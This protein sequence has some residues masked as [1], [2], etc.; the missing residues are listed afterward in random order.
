MHTI[1]FLGP[2]G[3]NGHDAALK[4]VS[5]QQ[6]KKDDYILIPCAS[7]EAIIQRFSQTE[8]YAILP[9][10]NSTTDKEVTEVVQ[11]MAEAAKDFT[12]SEVDTFTLTIHHCLLAHKSV[13]DISEL[14]SVMSHWQALGQCTNT[15]DK[16]GIIRRIDVKST[17]KAALHV[18]RMKKVPQ[19]GAIATRKAAIIYGLNILLENIENTK[20]NRT[21]F[22]VYHHSP[23]VKSV[24]VGIIGIKGKVGRALETFF[25]SLGCRVIGSDK[26]TE[27]TNEQVVLQADVVVFAV[28]IKYTEETI[29]S[30]VS[31]LGENQ[32]VMDMT[33]IKVPAVGAMKKGK[34]EILSLHQMFAPSVKNWKGQT[35]IGCRIKINKWN[36]W[37]NEML[38]QTRARIH[39]STPSEHD[40]YMTFVQALPH[41][42]TLISAFVITEEK[43][44]ISE[45]MH[46]TSP[47]YRLLMS[48]MGRI[49]SNPSGL[50]GDIL[51]ENPLVLKML[52]RFI[53]E[54]QA[55][56][57][58]IKKKDREAFAQKFEAA[59]RHFGKRHLA[60]AYNLFQRQ[61][62]LMVEDEATNLIE[63]RF[64]KKENH[65]GLL[66][67][68]TKIFARAK[69]NHTYFRFDK[70]G[71]NDFGFFIGIEEPIE[72]PHIQRALQRIEQKTGVVVKG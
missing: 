46:F 45:T 56:R 55:F 16:L 22:V 33:S 47:F 37:V 40:R 17:A 29:Q 12:I 54:A 27:L 10:Y 18:S 69:V 5:R 52:T 61:V 57:R 34:A 32:L 50:Y 51:M 35:I 11:A 38:I 20:R 28:P 60:K 72:S 3:S 53:K 2:H 41:S 63:L 8:G 62:S 68:I 43:I 9:V 25:L 48:S 71:D 70:N 7:H 39:F 13:Q 30:V 31:L 42:A 24:T 67:A 65:S 49:L 26:N 4:F 64:T 36:K 44:P 15:L 59:K 23:K 58:I 6:W 66:H 21:T 1:Y 19:V 14:T